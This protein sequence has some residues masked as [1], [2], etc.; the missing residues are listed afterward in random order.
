MSQSPTAGPLVVPM[1][2]SVKT[3][4][5]TVPSAVSIQI[6]PSGRLKSPAAAFVNSSAYAG[7][8]ELSR[9]CGLFP[10]PSS[11]AQ[12]I[13]LLNAPVKS[14]QFKNKAQ[15]YTFTVPASRSIPEPKP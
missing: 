8:P 1:M 4:S 2:S 7:E 11:E 5:G 14:A 6:D 15:L 10:V 3:A 9:V 12:L 13:I